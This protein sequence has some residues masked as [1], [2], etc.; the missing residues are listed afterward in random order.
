MSEKTFRKWVQKMVDT[1]GVHSYLDNED[2]VEDGELWVEC[3]E[4]GNRFDVEVENIRYFSTKRS[5]CNMPDD[6]K[7][8]T[9]VET[10]QRKEDEG[11]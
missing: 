5:L 8:M 10:N 6:V 3:P 9:E 11:K 4:C 2:D 1:Y 7:E